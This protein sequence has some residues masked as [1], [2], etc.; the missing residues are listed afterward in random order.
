MRVGHRCSG[1]SPGRDVRF[2]HEI[3]RRPGYLSRRRVLIAP[4][5]KHR[6]MPGPRFKPRSPRR[7]TRGGYGCAG[8]SDRRAKV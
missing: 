7:P 4:R 5:G 3:L 1:R 6:R 2:N 8:S